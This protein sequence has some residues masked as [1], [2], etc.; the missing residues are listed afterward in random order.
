M[1]SFIFSLF[2]I[3]LQIKANSR[4][5]ETY[6]LQNEIMRLWYDYETSSQIINVCKRKEKNNMHKGCIMWLSAVG[7]AEST[8]CKSMRYNNCRWLMSDWA[9]MKFDSVNDSIEYRVDR[10]YIYW[11][12]NKTPQDRLDRSIYCH[13]DCRHWIENTSIVI[14]YFKFKKLN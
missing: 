14:E 9:V 12:G 5:E 11:R 4:D 6:R 3:G 1:I 10:Y 13:W 7:V 8:A 2:A